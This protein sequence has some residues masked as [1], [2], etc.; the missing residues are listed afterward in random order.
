MKSTSSKISQIIFRLYLYS[1][2]EWS[3]IN[4]T[5]SNPGEKPIENDIDPVRGIIDIT[6]S[7]SINILLSTADNSG[8]RYIIKCILNG[9]RELLDL[10]KDE[11]SDEVIAVA[12]DTYA[13]LGIK[14][15]FF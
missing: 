1:G 8:E 7:P 4:P 15:N 3:E 10:D 14:R 13:P 2:D 9:I 5:S 12:I 11:F 6:L